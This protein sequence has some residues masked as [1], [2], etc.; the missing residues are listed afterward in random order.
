MSP[1]RIFD[2]VAIICFS[3]STIPQLTPPVNLTALGL[4]FFALGHLIP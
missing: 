1:G 3:I 4:A 2:I